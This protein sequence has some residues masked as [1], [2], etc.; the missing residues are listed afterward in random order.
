MACTSWGHGV[1]GL[2]VCQDGTIILCRSQHG[3]QHVV[4]KSSKSLEKQERVLE[5][6]RLGLTQEAAVDFVHTSGYAITAKGVERYVQALGGLERVHA[7]IA[8]GKSNLEIL[9]TCVPAASTAELKAHMSTLP[10]HLSS[11]PSPIEPLVRPDDA[12]LYDTVKMTLH[13]PADVSEAIK[14][15]AHAE[16][17]TQ[18]QMIVKLLTSALSRLPRPEDV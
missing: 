5:A 6:I 15:A 2:Q 8:E 4:P 9:A 12:P 18:Q 7:L 10:E 1:H 11:V 14:L 16:K 17:K 13:L 3:A